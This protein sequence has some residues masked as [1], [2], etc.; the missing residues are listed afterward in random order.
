MSVALSSGSVCVNC[1]VWSAQNY[2]WPSACL[3][4]ASLRF[5]N[6][7]I[8]LQ[9]HLGSLKAKLAKLKAEMVDGKSGGG[10]GAKASGFD[11][12]KVRTVCLSL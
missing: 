9:K 3:Q 5:T 7:E 11:V 10:G 2:R 8:C 4:S 1:R 12:S 6:V